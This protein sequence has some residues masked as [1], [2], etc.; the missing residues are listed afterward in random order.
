MTH[1][2]S[3]N[4]EPA[5]LGA[6]CWAIW[7]NAVTGAL[8]LLGPPLGCPE[9]HNLSYSCLDIS[10]AGFSQP[11]PGH[12]CHTEQAVPAMPTLGWPENLEFGL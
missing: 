3:E 7:A 9:I 11:T 10:H 1:L 4:A 5:H 12:Y 2:L 6:V 8:I